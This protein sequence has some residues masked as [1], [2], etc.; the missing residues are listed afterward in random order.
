M[1]GTPMPD[2]QGCSVRERALTDVGRSPRPHEE[3]YGMALLQPPSSFLGQPGFWVRRG[4][5]PEGVL[6]QLP[7]VSNLYNHL[8]PK[9][10]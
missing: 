1:A 2:R 10:P 9:V 8:G 3:G 5:G 4:R 6:K 7:W